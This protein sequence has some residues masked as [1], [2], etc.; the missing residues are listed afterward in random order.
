MK[1]FVTQEES[2]NPSLYHDSYEAY[3]ICKYPS[4]PF[5]IDHLS[6]C[7]LFILP[8]NFSGW[9]RGRTWLIDLLAEWMDR[10]SKIL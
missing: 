4:L 10:W 1:S 2:I 5:L 3:G 9:S 6:D 8:F 7:I